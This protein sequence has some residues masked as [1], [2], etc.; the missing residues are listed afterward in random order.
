MLARALFLATSALVVSPAMASDTWVVD[1]STQCK[2]QDLGWIKNTT[3]KWDGSC[4]SGFADG[5]G[6]L[7]WS[8]EGIKYFT[9]YMSKKTGVILNAGKRVPFIQQGQV[10]LTL[11][12]CHDSSRYRR[13]AAQISPTLDGTS[14]VIIAY[15]L[16]VA[17]QL[18]WNRCPYRKRTGLLGQTVSNE[19]EY[20]NV[21]VGIYQNGK[22]IAKARS[23]DKSAQT[24]RDSKSSTDDVDREWLEYSH[25]ALS[26][27]RSRAR[28]VVRKERSR[29]LKIAQEAQ[30]KLQQE[31]ERKQRLEREER[32]KR[33]WLSVLEGFGIEEAIQ[34]SPRILQ[35]NPF[36]Y[37]GK[38]VVVRAVLR[39][40][41]SRSMGVFADEKSLFEVTG[42]YIVSGIPDD[43]SI[44]DNVFFMFGK[45]LGNVEIPTGTGRILLPHLQFVGI[46]RSVDL[47]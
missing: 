46:H 37:E 9:E 3:V 18:A 17:E 20:S 42:Q 24:R 12:K 29:K 30:R 26:Q 7:E 27:A 28:D 35:K 10:Q 6:K 11:K 14:P 31:R 2:V 22:K 4:K 32:R 45:V 33:I 19:Y 16:S 8:S 1:P 13:V 41:R 44:P 5:T 36:K 25:P 47:L 38:V 23:Y 15:V 34:I 40:M 39:Q 21:D 43:I